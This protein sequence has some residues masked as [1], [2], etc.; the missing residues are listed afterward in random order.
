MHGDNEQWH[1]QSAAI[2][3]LLEYTRVSTVPTAALALMLVSKPSVLKLLQA[4]MYGRCGLSLAA[5]AASLSLHVG[6]GKAHSFVSTHTPLALRC[7]P[8]GQLWQSSCDVAACFPW[9]CLAAGQAVQTS[10]PVALEYVSA[11]HGAQAT[12]PVDENV[13]SA[14]GRQAVEELPSWSRLPAGHGTQAVLLGAT[15]CPRA[16]GAQ[17]GLGFLAASKNWAE[18]HNTSIGR[19]QLG[20]PVSASAPTLT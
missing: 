16:H 2:E 17:P 13:P 6:D 18:G 11:G 4:L 3:A 1:G 12:T 5:S 20:A 7:S 19:A 8:C 15:T 9:V 10:V 14:H